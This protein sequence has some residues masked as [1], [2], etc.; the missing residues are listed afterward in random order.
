MTLWPRQGQVWAWTAALCSHLKP[1]TRHLPWPCTGIS[2]CCMPALSCVCMIRLPET[3]SPAR[4][5]LMHTRV[6]CSSFKLLSTATF[7]TPTTVQ[8][9]LG[10]QGSCSL[11]SMSQSLL[12]FSSPLASGARIGRRV[13]FH[14]SFTLPASENGVSGTFHIT[15][16]GSY[17]KSSRPG[18]DINIVS[19]LAR[20]SLLQRQ[21]QMI[22]FKDETSMHHDHEPHLRPRVMPTHYGC[23]FDPET[24]ASRPD[25]HH[26]PTGVLE[27][28]QVRGTLPDSC[29]SS[30]RRILQMV[31]SH[32]LALTFAQG[33]AA[34]CTYTRHF[35]GPAETLVRILANWNQ[36]SAIYEETF[37]I[38]IAVVEVKIL[39][40]C[41]D[42]NGEILPWNQP[43][44]DD[45][46]I[47]E[48]LSAFSQ[49]R[50]AKADGHGLWHL[51]SRCN[52][53]PSV[54]IAWLDE[55]CST[56]SN[57]QI[58]GGQRQFVSGT[59][60]S[61]MY[62]CTFDSPFAYTFSVPTEFK[63]VAHEI[64]HNF[65]AI[66]DC[67]AMQCPT[68]CDLNSPGSCSCCPC[69]SQCDCDGQFCMTSN[70]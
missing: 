24:M 64:G 67:V 2:A 62:V 23:G 56:G 10:L 13:L 46:P 22:I 6:L 19:P 7:H 9:W 58:R 39:T 48:R 45:F 32:A 17:Q 63:V 4:S 54:G 42:F 61:T 41:G 5:W 31:C 34:D 40:G 21:S 65:G 3:R 14:G 25:D 44:T 28:R 8:S 36:I 27:K 57:L 70:P 18:Q 35:G 60:V 33:V 50:G 20:D 59:A 53:G 12:T 66:H 47:N 49:W 11:T 51:M 1:G 15:S 29:F 52:S 38:E 68:S 37:N 26:H 16:I 43:C 55:L 30:S 69:G